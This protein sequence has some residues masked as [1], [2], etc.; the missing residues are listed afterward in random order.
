MEPLGSLIPEPVVRFRVPSSEASTITTL[1]L[2]PNGFWKTTLQ[3]PPIPSP[4]VVII[5]DEAPQSP[6]PYRSTQ[7]VAPSP[8][9]PTEGSPSRPPTSL[10]AG[11][12]PSTTST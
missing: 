6:T 2:A 12:R 10:P 7:Q 3:P 11:T 4:P 1:C 9:A 8:S 5:V